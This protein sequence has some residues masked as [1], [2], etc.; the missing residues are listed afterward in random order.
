MHAAERSAPASAVRAAVV[1]A[2]LMGLWHARE[3][4][5]AGGVLVG[6]ADPDEEARSALVRRFTSARP[7]AALDRLLAGS[8]P[9]V[10]H[11]CTPL[12][13]HVEL[14]RRCLDAGAHV[15]AEKPLAPDA[16]STE[17]L[18]ARAEQRGVLL[19]PVH[20]YPFQRGAEF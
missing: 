9:L 4:S 12:E 5:R 6:V 17:E 3:L 15:L 16:A 13:T 11:L 1:G 14:I 18:L 10:V 2:G 20:Q 7:F 19:C 8:H